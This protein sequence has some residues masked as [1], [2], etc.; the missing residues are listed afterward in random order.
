[1]KKNLSHAFTNGLRGP[2]PFPADPAAPRVGSAGPRSGAGTIGR[3]ASGTANEFCRAVDRVTASGGLL[4][5]DYSGWQT[6]DA[7]RAPGWR[8]IAVA[9]IRRSRCH[10]CCRC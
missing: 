5:V 10:R 7:R 6:A 8:K 9:L 1:M 3:A 2:L 4:H